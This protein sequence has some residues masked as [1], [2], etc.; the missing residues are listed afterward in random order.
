[1]DE[2]ISFTLKEIGGG[3]VILATFFTF[4][5]AIW[6]NRIHLR[7]KYQFDVALK[8]LEVSHANK[9]QSL[10]HALQIERHAAQLG[11]AKLI[12]K[13][14]NIIDDVYKL[15]VE[16]HEAIYDT[17]RP[18]YFGRDKPSKQEAYE[19]ALPKFDSFVESFE[20]NKIYFSFDIAIKISEFYVAAA[21]TL[22][23]ARIVIKSGESLGRGDTPNIQK[24][25]EKVNHEMDQARKSVEK[26]FRNILRVDDV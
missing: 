11:H 16:L 18:D 7:E 21:Q 22:D 8:Q 9:T 26:D 15:L 25:F 23:Q 5:G 13:R 2:V 19:L 14:A 3:S 10:E 20:K 12:E 6:K 24:L 17:I 1:M 4:L